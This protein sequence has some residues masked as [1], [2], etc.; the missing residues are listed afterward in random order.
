MRRQR[1]S[2]SG[3][4]LDSLDVFLPALGLVDIKGP[5]DLDQTHFQISHRALG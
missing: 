5:G 3:S 1:Q 4:D 2:G